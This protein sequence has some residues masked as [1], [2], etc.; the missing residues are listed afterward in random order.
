VSFVRFWPLTSMPHELQTFAGAIA[1]LGTLTAFPHRRHLA[2]FPEALS[3][4]LPPEP[5]PEHKIS[6][7]II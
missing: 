3:G 2:V 5:Q 4:T 7:D 6:I 1:A